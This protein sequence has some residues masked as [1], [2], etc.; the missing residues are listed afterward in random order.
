MLP[1]PSAAGRGVLMMVAA[2]AVFTANDTL[3]KQ[4]AAELPPLQVVFL[5][6]VFATLT[7]AALVLATGAAREVKRLADPA[8]TLR[9]VVEF[10]SIATFI[11]A[12][13]ALPIADVI[14]I[15]NTAPLL[16][17]PLAALWFG[18]KVGVWRWALVALGFVGALMVTQPGRAGFDP[19]ILLAF[20][21]ALAQTGRDLLSRRID[22][23]I[24]WSI[25]ALSTVVVVMLLAGLGTLALG[26]TPPSLDQL[27]RLALAG[28]CLAVG[29][30]WLFIAFRL[31]PVGTVAPFAYSATLWA[32]LAG[33]AVFGDPLDP[34]ALAGIAL[35]TATGVAIAR[36]R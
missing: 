1:T 34:L 21:T 27:A 4:A 20:G 30:A 31:A 24:P 5:R 32:V 29:H 17:I 15:A 18:E 16:S 36:G 9:S 33:V 28:A 25:V 6:G 19:L 22:P 3:M 14:A 2:M 13:A 12:L 8:V 11:V 26:W 7:M 23:A 35:L 10:G